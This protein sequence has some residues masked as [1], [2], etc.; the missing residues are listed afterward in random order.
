MARPRKTTTVSEELIEPAA[1]AEDDTLP[2]QTRLE[3]E[4]GR[5]VLAALAPRDEPAPPVEPELEP[6][7]GAEPPTE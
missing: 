3:M 7:P 1:P 2:L 6:N 5:A 4:A